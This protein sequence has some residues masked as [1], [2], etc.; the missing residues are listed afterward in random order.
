MRDRAA[1]EPAEH[2]L[3]P[4]EDSLPDPDGEGPEDDRPADLW[5]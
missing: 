2:R 3:T 5:F 1:K 4:E